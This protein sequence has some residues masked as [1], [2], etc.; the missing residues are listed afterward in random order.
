MRL[1]HFDDHGGD[2]SGAGGLGPA[3]PVTEARTQTYL[4]RFTVA[5]EYPIV[6][7]RELF[8]PAIARELQW[9][10]QQFPV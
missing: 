9:V 4:Q 3:G 2:A 1:D 6:F 7:T 5:H 10:K 8:A